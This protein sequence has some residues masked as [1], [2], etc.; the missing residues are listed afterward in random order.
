[1]DYPYSNQLGAGAAPDNWHVTGIKSFHLAE[2]GRRGLTGST[3]LEAAKDGRPVTTSDLDGRRDSIPVGKTSSVHH[4][5]S[6]P[7]NADG[8][9]AMANGHHKPIYDGSPARH[10]PPSTSRQQKERPGFA[11]TNIIVDSFD[12]RDGNSGKE[13][14]FFTDGKRRVDFVIVYEQGLHKAGGEPNNRVGR[15]IDKDQQRAFFERNL[16]EAGLNLEEDAHLYESNHLHTPSRNPS[17]NPSPHP[18]LRPDV[19]GPSPRTTLRSTTFVKIHAPFEV[20]CLQAEK[21]NLKM[22]LKMTDPY[23]DALEADDDDGMEGESVF[24]QFFRYLGK[25]LTVFRRKPVH[26]GAG[27]VVNLN[28]VSTSNG[29]AGDLAN[30]KAARDKQNSGRKK[31]RIAWPFSRKR[32]EMY[33]LGDDPPNTF[34]TP[35][36]RLEIVWNMLQQARNDPEDEKRRGIERLLDTGVYEKAFALHDGDYKH[37]PTPGSVPTHHDCQREKLRHIWASWRSIF[38]RQPLQLIRR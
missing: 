6:E 33:D 4:L 12:D 18:S 32:M 21:L 3:S 23:G 36:Q 17:R 2:Q 20:L 29:H 15:F 7:M 31:G 9:R 34:F 28:I 27:I 14:A 11:T 19:P 16:I 30:G 5:G 25:V 38:R 35:T 13:G 1:M 8:G 10:G 37:H 24:A 26:H 22:P